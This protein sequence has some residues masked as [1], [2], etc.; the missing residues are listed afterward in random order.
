M[1]FY[2]QISTLCYIV[3]N[4]F[5]FLLQPHTSQGSMI[6]TQALPTHSGD[7]S[8]LRT[9]NYSPYPNMAD[10]YVLPS[11]GH[12]NTFI[13]IIFNNQMLFRATFHK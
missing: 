4:L 13:I 8:P 9:T 2:Y 5:D 1:E 10:K 12:L 6:N 7:N 11:S 3:Y